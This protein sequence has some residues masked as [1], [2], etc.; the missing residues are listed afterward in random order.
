MSIGSWVLMLSSFGIPFSALQDA[1]ARGVSGDGSL[2]LHLLLS[3]L[4]SAMIKSPGVPAAAKDKVSQFLVNRP[5]VLQLFDVLLAV[6][7]ITFALGILLNVVS[8]KG[9]RKKIASVRKTLETQMM[10]TRRL[11]T[12]LS[13]YKKQRLQ[14]L[15]FR[16]PN[17]KHAKHRYLG[18]YIEVSWDK[19][20]VTRWLLLDE[21]SVI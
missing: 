6:G 15:V 8:L 1:E 20:Q 21:T 4:A 7:C 13:P 11:Y 3:P 5:E 17:P 2:T 9:R 19:L 18:K 14:Q 10:M 12:F 16:Y